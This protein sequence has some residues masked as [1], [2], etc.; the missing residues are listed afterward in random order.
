M[1]SAST[2]E[3]GKESPPPTFREVQHFRR[4]WLWLVV[5]LP[6]ALAWWPFVHQILGGRPVGEHPLPDWGVWLVWLLIGLGLP[7]FFGLLRMEVEV[8]DRELTIVYRPLARRRVSLT[9]IVEIEA[10][11]YSALKEYGGWGIKGWSR[12][13]MAYNVSGDQGVELQL[14]DGRSLLIGSRRPDEL[15]EAIRRHCRRLSGE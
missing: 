10:R 5:L 9:D 13:K 6:T 14:K 15:A 2:E 12:D 11:R 4:S 1:G 3:L 7:L 8:T